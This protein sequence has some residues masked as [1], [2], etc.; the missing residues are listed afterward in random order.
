M[1]KTDDFIIPAMVIETG[2]KILV[3]NPICEEVDNNPWGFATDSW[4]FTKD[5]RCF[6]SDELIFS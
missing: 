6:H 2:E 3:N 5:K 1:I 4:H